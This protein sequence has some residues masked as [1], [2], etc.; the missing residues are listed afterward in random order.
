MTGTDTGLT[1]GYHLK[2]IIARS[3]YVKKK[4][5]AML[6]LEINLAICT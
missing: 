6:V 4:K 3:G 5:E 2:V 1:L